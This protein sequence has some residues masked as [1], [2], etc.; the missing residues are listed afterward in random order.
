MIEIYKHKAGEVHREQ[1]L[2]DFE[3]VKYFEIHLRVMGVFDFH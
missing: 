1:T 2:Q 3:N